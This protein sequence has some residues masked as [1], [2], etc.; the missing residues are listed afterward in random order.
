MNRWSFGDGRH[1]YL[2][3][4]PFSPLASIDYTKTSFF[5]HTI[6]LTL[7]SLLS[8]ASVLSTSAVA[9]PCLV[10]DT[11]F[12]LYALGFNGKDY[13][14]GTMDSWSSGSPK[15]ITA[16]GR[17][18][19]DAD[20]TMCFLSQFFNAVYVVNGDKSNPSDLYILNAGD[21]SWTKQS[22]NVGTF[23]IATSNMILDHDTNLFYAV[24]DD[25]TAWSLD[26]GSLTAADSETK[27][28]NELGNLGFTN[29]PSGYKSTMALAQNHIHFM[30]IEAN[31]VDIFVIHFSYYQPETQTYGADFP[32]EHGQAAS[33]FMPDGQGVQQQ[34]AYIPDGGKN[35]YVLNVESNTTTTLAGPSSQDADARY[36]AT[37]DALVQLA[38]DGSVNYIPVTGDN[39][40][41]GSWSSVSALSS[42]APTSSSGSSASSTGKGTNT[43]KGAAATHSGSS[44]S[45]SD[46][47]EDGAR[48][49]GVAFTGLIASVVLA[50]FGLYA[51]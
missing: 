18:P 35:V 26:M 3:G 5:H 14:A 47:N 27:T 28:W 32:A 36:Y 44:S 1:D 23:G 6:M 10:S 8:L 50:T 42:V 24:A 39:V 20:N 30:G 51:L 34:F 31:S 9:K 40:A 13:N 15:D 38:S 16:S 11:G 17:P 43:A 19:F 4:S 37:S 2:Y 7:V 41:S 48:A 25:N 29:L 45:G 49:Q 22:T 33:I 12:N 21:G 46:N